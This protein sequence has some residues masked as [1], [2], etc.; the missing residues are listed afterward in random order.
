MTREVEAELSSP[1]MPAPGS[2]PIARR[3]DFEEAFGSRWAVWVGGVALAL[4]GL[5]LIRYSIEAGFFGPGVRL[6]MGVAF[7]VAAAAASEY[8]R[9]TDRILNLGAVSNAIGRSGANIPGVLAG[10]SVLSGFGV[11]FA[12]HAIYGFIGPGVAFALMGLIGLAALAASLLHGQLLGVFGLLGS[13]ATPALVAS[14][15]PDFSSLSLFLSF[16]T[17]VAF[18]LH[19]QRPSRLVTLGAVAGHGVWTLLIALFARSVVWPSFLLVVGAVLG[20]A[21]LKEW[22][23]FRGRAVRT[24]WL[25]AGFDAIGLAAIAVPLIL[26]GV[27]WVSDGGP[28]SIHAAILTTVLIAIIAAVRRRDLA[29]L[30]PLAAAAAAG[31]ILLW[32]SREAAFGLSPDIFFRLVRLS[33]EGD[34]GAG[35]GWTAAVMAIIVGGLPF[36]AL[37]L[38]KGSGA[39]GFVVRGCLG[40]ASALG[41]ICLMLAAALR[42]NG[43]ERSTG[44][45]ALSL[46]LTIALF[47]ASEALLPVE[48]RNTRARTNPLALI[49]SAA[50]A[51]GGSIALGLAVAF[52][53]RETWLV[54]GLAVG[55]AGVAI[56]ASLR[57]IPLLRSMSAALATAAFARLLWQPILT[58]MG[59]WPII[60]WI[61][62]AYAAPAL[63]FAVGAMVLRGREDRPR[64]V[65]E[66]LASFFAAAF[67]ML[68]IRQIFVGPDLR[69]DALQLAEHYSGDPRNRLFEEI[70]AY[71]VAI[72]FIGAGLQ[73]IARRLG[74][75]IFAPAADVAAVA[76]LLVSLGGFCALLNPLFD[77]TQVLGPPIFN[78]LLLYV[79]VGGVLGALGFLLDRRVARSRIGECLSACA[80]VLVS[81]GA[82]LIVRQ[83]FAGPQLAPQSIETVG[84]AEAV[85]VTLVLLALTAAAR[86]WREAAE[87]RVASFALRAL[88]L[89]AIGWA[90]L[91]L[92][93][94]RNP[95]I[96]LSGVSG[97]VIFNRILWGYGAAVLGFAGLALWVRGA[98]PEIGPSL[99]RTAKGGALLGAFLLLRHG[100]HGPALAS[101]VPITLAEAGC[102]ASIGFVAAIAVMITRSVRLAGWSTTASARTAAVCSCSIFALFSGMVASPWATGVPLA[103]PMIFDNALVGYLAPSFLAFVAAAWA[104][105]YIAAPSAQRVFGATAIVGAL[106][107]ILIEVRR[108]FVG[109]N[110]LVD[111]ESAAELYLYT[112]AILLYGVTQ[113]ALGFRLQSRDLRL[114]SLAVVTIAICKAFLVDMSGLEGLLRAL[115]FIGLG[116]CLVGIGLAYQRLLRR[117]IAQQDQRG[118]APVST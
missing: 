91:M 35:I 73:I 56:V 34:A 40:F 115:S 29:P 81:L 54:V 33:F 82:V 19:G 8:L 66:A 104:R 107:Y 108:W 23:A 65:H 68:E 41:P 7:S 48:R 79:V 117:E 64:S 62:P 52:V 27:L 116:A 99:A 2:A 43:F 97:P 101:D 36:G 45:A 21:L 114:A 96:D 14:T 1:A 103:G 61:I 5:F 112:V 93:L 67:V 71:I 59:A 4:G 102:Y 10:V 46:L 44:F 110:L 11:V 16:V 58:D 83:A 42:S 13:Y 111:A 74:G 92:G 113:L 17:M 87:N 28:A 53:L 6:L 31:M 106:I 12:A 88:A 100:F 69:P 109:P 85:M 89:L 118:D 38:R 72:G 37:L 75:R 24:V 105:E 15:A 55:A 76:L 20:L 30:A 49:G 78:R 95:M 63:C 39:G 57:P 70:A 98:Q 26:S 94:V 50:Y 84:F 86:V 9:R 90:V 77:G 47:A 3:S 51:A 25:V 60:N 32:P 18:L 80:I 22:P